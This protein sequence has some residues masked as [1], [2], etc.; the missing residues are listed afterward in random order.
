VGEGP[1]ANEYV[2]WSA[3]DPHA[4]ATET[5]LSERSQRMVEALCWKPAHREPRCLECHGERT[6]NLNGVSHDALGTGCRSCHGA[7]GDW[8]NSHS[9]WGDLAENER[10][11]RYEKSGMVWLRDTGTLA[12]TC[13]GCHVGATTQSVDH[14]MIAAGHPRLNFELGSYLANL[15][16][17]W[18]LKQRV[19]A[20]EA[21]QWR[22]G[23]LV[24]ARVALELLAHRAEQ[25]GKQ[26]V[27]W[28]EL[29]EYRCA[30]C[31]RDLQLRSVKDQPPGARSG[32]DYPVLQ[33]FAPMNPWYTTLLE[34]LLGPL[35]ELKDLQREMRAGRASPE[36]QQKLAS[37]TRA[38]IARLDRPAPP[39]STRTFINHQLDRMP[40]EVE[41]E[42]ATQRY[43]ALCALQGTWHAGW[44][45][46]NTPTRR[47]ALQ[48]VLDR[49]GKSLVIPC[50]RSER[51]PHLGDPVVPAGK[52]LDAF[53]LP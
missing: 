31:H 7:G 38:L 3:L 41:W 33:G 19:A 12:R 36:A 6:D 45:E 23:Q 43:L 15:P 22:T 44:E 53:R 11:Q 26:T 51:G 1:Q 4:R 21:E 10:R 32:M 20:E 27:V 42:V 24:V 5:L 34:D 49:V 52:D 40:Q 16:R 50:D 8:V 14:D 29:S 17:H 30:A 2:Q 48:Q 37:Q 35:Q 47:R 46:K 28:P 13:A 39:F 25:G 9:G 18:R